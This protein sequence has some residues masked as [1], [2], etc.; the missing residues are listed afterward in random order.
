MKIKKSSL[1]LM[2]I[3]LILTLN[4][5]CFYLINPDKIPLDDIGFVLEIILFVLIFLSNKKINNKEYDYLGI[6]ISVI[7]LVI[8]SSITANIQ[9]EQPFFL[10]LRAQRHWIM[11]LNMYFPIRYL[12]KNN[13]I[14][15]NGL[16]NTIYNFSI[17]YLVIT[18]I[19]YVLANKLI[20][21]NVSV[22]NHY[23][24]HKFYFDESVLVLLFSIT[25]YKVI[26]KEK[27]NKV[28]N[29]ILSIWTLIFIYQFTKYRTIL[30]ALVISVTI[31]VIMDK[32]FSMKKIGII[33]VIL[34]GVAIF[35]NTD[36][37]V[38]ILEALKGNDGSLNMRT[39]GREFYFK[40]LEGNYI[41]GNGFISIL[42]PKSY[43]E[44]GIAERIYY[45]DNGI[46]GLM[47]YYGLIGVI[48]WLIMNIKV[49]YNALAIRKFTKDFSYLIFITINLLV[50]T[51]GI[52]NYF[53]GTIVVAIFLAILETRYKEIILK[54]RKIKMEEYKYERTY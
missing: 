14:S 18:T 40:K 30:L 8:I 31:F 25:F 37:G 24:S 26:S 12:L 11:A 1:Y 42:W 9:Y 13:K 38:T 46:F 16:V 3:F 47:F 19:Q 17:I 4:F 54:C 32:G 5:H 36:L 21:L 29:L 35:I 15:I 53:D 43:I 52:P 7:I 6:T 33:S 28:L 27:N 20:F 51:T 23:G 22:N 2:Y 50:I 45:T 44:G 34:F 39:V 49:L 48:W 10:G 41:W